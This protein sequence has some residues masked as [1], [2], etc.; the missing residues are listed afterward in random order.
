M[1]IYASS[2]T[3]HALQMLLFSLDERQTLPRKTSGA[4]RSETHC[5]KQFCTAWPEPN[6]SHSPRYHI[7]ASS[8][9]LLVIHYKHQGRWRRNAHRL[10]TPV[11]VSGSQGICW[12]IM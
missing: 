9:P 7:V 1:L 12:E 5:T 10:Q 11:T 8:P 2:T 4:I 6:W 3:A